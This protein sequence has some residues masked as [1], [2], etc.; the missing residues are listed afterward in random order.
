MSAAI[1]DPRQLARDRDVAIGAAIV[2]VLQPARDAYD[3]VV[4]LNARHRER[5]GG[6]WGAAECTREQELAAYR[7]SVD[8]VAELGRE[9]A[10]LQMLVEAA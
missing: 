7:V 5:R 4:K 9:M 10:R 8:A 2:D 3:A 1:V 6:R